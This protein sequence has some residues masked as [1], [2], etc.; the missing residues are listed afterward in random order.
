[1]VK[2]Y[3]VLTFS[4]NAQAVKF[5]QFLEKAMRKGEKID[6]IVKGNRVRVI[7]P[8]GADTTRVIARVKELFKYWRMSSAPTRGLYR[9]SLPLVFLLS[10][11]EISIPPSVIAYVLM[12]AG[13]RAE[14]QGSQL[15]SDAPLDLVIKVAE[16][17]SQAYKEAVL[18]N[19]TPLLKRLAASVSA[20]LDI[21]P[22]EALQL[23]SRAEIA[24]FLE[25]EGRWIMRVGERE[26]L[27]RLKKL[28]REMRNGPK[29]A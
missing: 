17:A 21:T 13:Y 27:L 8:K 2:K 26:A 20:A 24:D 25:S 14:I 9:H 22:E 3:F 5:V 19:A 7:I 18:L 29:G 1:M 12:L 28:S 11:L 4:S 23:L 16:K 15:V 10:E 6:F